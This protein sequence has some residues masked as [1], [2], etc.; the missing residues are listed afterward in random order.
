MIE[1]L[2]CELQTQYDFRVSF[3]SGA[4]G[5]RIHVCHIKFYT[6]L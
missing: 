2:N 4:I 5:T 6:R 1:Q 3:R